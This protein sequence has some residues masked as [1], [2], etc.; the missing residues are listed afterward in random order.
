[1]RTAPALLWTS[2]ALLCLVSTGASGQATEMVFVVANSARWPGQTVRA[3]VASDGTQANTSAGAP[4]L[5]ADGRLIAFSSNASNLVGGDT[6]GAGDV[7]VRDRETGQTTRVSLASG[8]AQANNGSS[9]TSVSAD[10][11][12]VAFRSGASNPANATEGSLCCSWNEAS[13]RRSTIIVRAPRSS[14]AAATT[15]ALRRPTWSTV[16]RPVAALAFTIL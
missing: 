5:S 12:F 3:S 7:F 11:R 13:K 4:V 16:S 10:G 9:T 14:S 2:G 15:R 6:N 8:G 1:M